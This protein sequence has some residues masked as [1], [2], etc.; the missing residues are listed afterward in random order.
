MRAYVAAHGACEPSDFEPVGKTLPE[1]SEPLA[2]HA[3]ALSACFDATSDH[4]VHVV[5]RD[6]RVEIAGEQPGELPSPET[7]ACV[8]DELHRAQATL[9]PDSVLY[10]RVAREDLR[11]DS[12]PIGWLLKD[13]IHNAV[14]VQIGDL[15]RC[16]IDA[17]GVLPYVGGRVVTQFVIGPDG[18]IQSAALVDNGAGEALVGC[19]IVHA[20]R[21]WSMPKPNG[22]GTVI[23]EIPFVAE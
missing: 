1:V 8:F 23:V 6:G 12:S 3:S 9:P 2:A 15:Q 13:V 18:G 17:I 20:V 10:G 19:C 11:F 4:E 14:R 16:F 7:L 22:G 21:R 5:L